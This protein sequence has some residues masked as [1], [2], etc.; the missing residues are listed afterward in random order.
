MSIRDTIMNTVREKIGDYYPFFLCAART[1]LREGELI[2]LRPH[3]LDFNGRFINVQ[4][5]ISRGKVTTPKN[6]KTRRVDMSLQ[7]TNTLDAFVA[8]KKAEAIRKEIER[9]EEHRGEVMEGWLFTTP[10][11]SQLDPNNMRKHVFYRGLDLAGLRRVRFHDLRHTFASLLIQQGESLAYIKDQLGH[12]SIQITVDT[13]GHLVPG[14]NRQA[15]DRLDDVEEVAV[16]DH[17]QSGHKMVT[18]RMERGA[19]DA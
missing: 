14:G 19:D 17:R 13:Y 6:G 2:G 3:D 7:L 15:V 4:R 9:P 16:E 8:A 12:H 1:G 18:S 11:G 10:N 5:S